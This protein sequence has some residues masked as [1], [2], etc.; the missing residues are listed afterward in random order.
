MK[1]QRTIAAICFAVSL[2]ATGIAQPVASGY[3]R[4]MQF[5]PML[6]A[7]PQV[8]TA[9]PAVVLIFSPTSQNADIVAKFDAWYRTEKPP[10]VIAFG[11]VSGT[12]EYPI[13]VVEEVLRQRDLKIPV[14]FTQSPLEGTGDR[15]LVIQNARAKPVADVSAAGINAALT[16]PAG[17]AVATPRPAVSP[18]TTILPDTT[19]ATAEAP[20]PVEA[21]TP[22]TTEP[23]GSQPLR[24]GR[25]TYTNERY[26]F[27][28]TFP[29]GRTY[30]EAQNG[31]GALSK[32]PDTSSL[33]FRVWASSN[34]S[35]DEGRPGAMDMSEY[36]KRHLSFIAEEYATRVNVDRKFQIRDDAI[37][38]R[39]Y[40]YTFVRTSPSTG[41]RYEVR[42]RI[43]VFEVNGVFKVANVEGDADEFDRR[44]A[45][46]EQYMLS[47]EPAGR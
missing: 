9:D 14:F 29:A 12:T 30:I 45:E 47:F 36:L 5:D 15:V 33:D 28:V 27:T 17:L 3:F 42:G 25:G 10:N 38:G 31:D 8:L 1:L 7:E 22:V 43:Q 21:G 41:R 6:G 24:R 40:T 35:T 44:S 20:P 34:S 26:G 46:I 16:A 18:A 37:E 11:I 23:V 4:G 39:D 32:S 13:D 19:P 2:A